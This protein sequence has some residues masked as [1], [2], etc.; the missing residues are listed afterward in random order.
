MNKN[1]RSKYGFLYTIIILC[2]F[3]IGGCT[4]TTF[5]TP[6]SD[7]AT[8][9]SIT[10]NIFDLPETTASTITTT[11]TTTINSTAI[12]PF[13]LVAQQF[14]QL[15]AW[16]KNCGFKPSTCKIGDFTIIGSEFSDNFTQMMSDYAKNNIYSL[17]NHGERKIYGQTVE[18]DYVNMVATINGCVYD[19]MILYLDGSIF[20]DKIASSLTSW[21]MLWQNNHWNW[22]DF[23]VHKKIYNSNICEG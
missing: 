14:D 2:C 3:I 18:R 5:V 6:R 22:I 7:I 13:D 4:A 20:D 16:R 15:M 10:P 21:K 9:T 8:Q 11:N 1:P 12:D 23:E 17:P 19:T